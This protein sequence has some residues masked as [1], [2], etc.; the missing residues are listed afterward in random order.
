MLAYL[1]VAALSVWCSIRP[2]IGQNI[3]PAY[4]CCVNV[5]CIYFVITVDSEA[6][7]STVG[8]KYSVDS[9][10]VDTSPSDFKPVVCNHLV[11]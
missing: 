6:W 10:T 3:T 9:S 5:Y 7:L 8:E 11:V 1:Q 2:P 4:N